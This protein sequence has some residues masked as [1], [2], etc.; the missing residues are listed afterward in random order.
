M[1]PFPIFFSGRANVCEWFDDEAGKFRIEVTVRN[2]TWGRLFGYTG[3]FD[4][5]F[6]TVRPGEV[7]EGLKPVREEQRE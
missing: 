1:F 5:E 4:V 7:P 2:R 6:R 3:S